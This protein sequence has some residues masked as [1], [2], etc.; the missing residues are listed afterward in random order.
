M[1]RIATYKDI[2]HA[3]TLCDWY[4]E[5]A[6][7]RGIGIAKREKS[8]IEKK[9]IDGNSIIA[10]NETTGDLIG[11]CYIE[12]FD[13][14]TF[15]VNSGLIIRPDARK[16]GL[17]KK[18]KMKVFKL[19]RTKYP[20]AKI[21]GITTSLAV[22]RIN[23]E[24]GYHPVTFSE[25]TSSE[26]FWKGCKSCKNYSILQENNRKMCLCT[27]MVYDKLNDEYS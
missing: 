16:E 21:F 4:E 27:A 20:K 18:M 10:F 17:G 22:M 9:M 24:I 3:Q 26:D 25:L 12:T 1:M 6:K 19:S 15:V 13:D 7:A 5:S 23:T 14:Q 8:Y 2:I 11:F